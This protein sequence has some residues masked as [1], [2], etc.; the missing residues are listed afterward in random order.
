MTNHPFTNYEDAPL[1][2]S[3]EFSRYNKIKDKIIN[4]EIKKADW[5]IIR[6]SRPGIENKLKKLCKLAGLSALTPHML[7]HNSCTLCAKAGFNE[8]QLRI[9]YGWSPTSKMPSKYTHL[10]SVDIDD[11][12]KQITGFKEPDK[13][14]KSKLENIICWNCQE[15]NVPTNKFCS[16]CGANLNPK[17]EEITATAI[18]TGLAFQQMSKDP[19]LM[20]KMMEMMAEKWEQMQKGKK[21]E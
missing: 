20:M 19:E 10:A 5:E 12:I 21:K 8:M 14:M 16:I 3:R 2:Y 1:F 7:R 18:E 15:E 6:L 4:K 17:K 13:L 11:K 9:R